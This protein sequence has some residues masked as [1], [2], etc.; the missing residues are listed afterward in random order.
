MAGPSNVEATDSESLA[1]LRDPACGIPFDIHFEIENEE[2]VNVGTVGGHKAVLALKSPVF[3]A[4]LFGVLAESGDSVKIRRTSMFAFTEM[5]RYMHDADMDWRP[6]S[7]DLRELMRLADLAERYNLPGLTGGIVDYAKDCLYPKE[8]LLEIARLAEDFDMF[9]EVSEALL[10]N[11]ATFLNTTLETPEDFNKIA[12]EWSEM[13][14]E[15]M[16]TA[17]RLLA[18]VDHRKLAYVITEE[19]WTQ[20]II[21]HLRHIWLSIQPRLRLKQLKMMFDEN[22]EEFLD[23][24]KRS[25]KDGLIKDCNAFTALSRSLWICQ[26]KDEERAAQEDASLTVDTLVEDGFT[27]GESIRMHLDMISQIVAEEEE[28]LNK[29]FFDE[30]W[31]TMIESDSIPGAKSITLS[32][33]SSNPEIINRDHIAEKLR[34]S[35][36]DVKGLP[37]YND[38]CDV[39]M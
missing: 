23:G 22:K 19:R 2:G 39:F 24:L 8:R 27:H 14:D 35:D 31:E 25:I 16:G 17:F 33:F 37:E 10:N 5:L 36:D 21:S 20:K 30:I 11:C 4:M 12:K 32:W 9:T 7:L 38:A 6:W 15:S 26:M 1:Y 3:K 28:S 18:L 29:E 13:E 34:S